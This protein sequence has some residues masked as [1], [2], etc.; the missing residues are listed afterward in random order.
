MTPQLRRSRAA[1]RRSRN[2]RLVIAVTAALGTT[3]AGL[4]AAIAGPDDGKKILTREHIDAPYT[5]RDD[6][7]VFDLYAKNGEGPHK[8]CLL[9]TSP[10]P[11]DK[12]QSRM[13]SSA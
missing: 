1:G 8:L 3:F 5:V 2:T 10:S 12:R 9:Y 4:P 11:R 7:G 13:P 6:A